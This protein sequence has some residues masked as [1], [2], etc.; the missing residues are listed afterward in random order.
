[1]PKFLTVGAFKESAGITTLEIIRNP[2]TGMLFG[3]GDNGKRI[4]V[5]QS[6]DTTANMRIL[7]SEIGDIDARTNEAYTVD[8]L[9]EAPCLVNA[10]EVSDNVL[11]TL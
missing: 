7:I 5:Q 4:R 1:M 8:T 6:L 10:K 9:P 3:Q 11:A 2:N